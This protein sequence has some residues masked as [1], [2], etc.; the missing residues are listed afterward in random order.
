M[1]VCEGHAA[2]RAFVCC[3][4]KLKSTADSL[5][6]TFDSAKVRQKKHPAEEKSVG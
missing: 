1:C 6:S 2:F 4:N 5:F 3:S